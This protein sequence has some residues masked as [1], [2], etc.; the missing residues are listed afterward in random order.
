MVKIDT[1]N[2]I[3][4]IIANEQ[5]IEFINNHENFRYRN[6]SV[7]DSMMLPGDNLHLSNTGI[8]RILGNLR[9]SDMANSEL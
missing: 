6:D 9:L 7:D 1:L 5:D 4:K 2:Q 8:K 3:I